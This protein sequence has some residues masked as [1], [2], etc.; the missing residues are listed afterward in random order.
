VV[1]SIIT[2]KKTEVSNELW[3]KFLKKLEAKE[4]EHSIDSIH[5]TINSYNA[6]G[7]VWYVCNTEKPKK[8]SKMDLKTKQEKDCFKG[9]DETID[10]VAEKLD[11]GKWE[12]DK[13]NA[14]VLQLIGKVLIGIG[15][16]LSDIRANLEKGA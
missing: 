13:A 16:I 4:T 12:P 15:I 10:S 2:I 5:F 7:F 11:S 6:G 3:T 8:E 14:V 1:N 9:I